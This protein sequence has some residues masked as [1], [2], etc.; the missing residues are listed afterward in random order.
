LD[1][2]AANIA[3]GEL[4]ARAGSGR[5]A[6]MG[7]GQTSCGGRPDAEKPEIPDEPAPRGDCGS[8]ERDKN[9]AVFL[10]NLKRAA[11]EIPEAKQLADGVAGPVL[12][13][14]VAV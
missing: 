1:R 6:F 4:L 11:A 9:F 3:L 7:W 8:D 10:G 5:V 13:D 2:V 14:V 12:R